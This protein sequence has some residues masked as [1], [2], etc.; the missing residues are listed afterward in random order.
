MS[1]RAIAFEGFA[2]CEAWHMSDHDPLTLRADR[3]Q[4]LH[5]EAVD[6]G[7]MMVR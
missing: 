4:K 6:V 5:Q 3:A 1:E 2:P 7:L